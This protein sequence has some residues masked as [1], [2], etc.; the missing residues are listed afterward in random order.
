MNSLLIWISTLLLFIYLKFFGNSISNLVLLLINLKWILFFQKKKKKK[1][2]GS[3]SSKEQIF[4][5]FCGCNRSIG[6][7]GVYHLCTTSSISSIIWNSVLDYHTMRIYN[8]QLTKAHIH[9]RKKDHCI[10]E[11]F[12]FQPFFFFLQKGI[13]SHITLK[14]QSS[15]SLTLFSIWHIL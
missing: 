4:F 14:I 1:R 9:I 15:H 6:T 5:F 7:G 12:W 2:Q 10:G 13:G 8:V 3:L 11:R